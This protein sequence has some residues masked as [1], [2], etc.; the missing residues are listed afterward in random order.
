MDRPRIGKN[1]R[2]ADV[3]AWLGPTGKIIINAGGKAVVCDHCPCGCACACSPWPPSSWPCGG[4]LET[5]SVS[6]E[7]DFGSG[8]PADTFTGITVT[9]VSGTPCAW[10]G[11]GTSDTLGN[12]V[13]LY[14][15]LSPPGT[16]PELEACGFLLGG[17]V[18]SEG[19]HALDAVTPSVPPGDYVN[20][21]SSTFFEATVS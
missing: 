1:R 5:Y 17:N 18:D 8:N 20:P 7:Y 3:S 12:T 4:L 10:A 19:L 11:S 21:P 9:A 15:E 16:V 13:D 2:V 14:L 6:G